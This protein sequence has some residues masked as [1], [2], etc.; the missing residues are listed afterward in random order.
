MHCFSDFGEIG[1]KQ[2]SLIDRRLMQVTKATG[3]L[4]KE[5]FRAASVVNIHDGKRMH[6]FRNGG[7]RL[8]EA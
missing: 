1:S 8:R 6:L 7:D 2:T 3:Y 4:T 5:G